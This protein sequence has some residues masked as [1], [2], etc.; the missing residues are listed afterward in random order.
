LPSH[1]SPI[2]TLCKASFSRFRDCEWE[3]GSR[4]NSSLV[5]R[6][7][8]GH[9]SVAPRAIFGP[10]L[11]PFGALDSGVLCRTARLF[12]AR[13]RDHVL[14]WNPRAPPTTSSL[15]THRCVERETRNIPQSTAER[16]DTCPS[17]EWSGYVESVTTPVPVSVPHGI[18][19]PPR[20]SQLSFIYATLRL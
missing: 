2:K 5:L 14:H 3:R 12:R 4:E 17:S 6:R 19:V 15:T 11:T 20:P 10:P 13:G 8:I 1:S 7:V 18:R 9:V 16:A